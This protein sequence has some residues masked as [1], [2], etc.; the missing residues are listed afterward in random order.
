M[1]A[2]KVTVRQIPERLMPDE[3]NQFLIH[4]PVALGFDSNKPLPVDR[5][6]NPAPGDL[7]PPEPEQWFLYGSWDIKL[8][9]TLITLGYPVDLGR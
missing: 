7:V 8:A 6:F 1:S 9:C 5:L 2:D 3:R 4:N